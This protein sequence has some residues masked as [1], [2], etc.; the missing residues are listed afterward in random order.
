LG[1]PSAAQTT[2]DGGD[3]ADGFLQSVGWLCCVAE[4]EAGWV[5][6]M[7]VPGQRVDGDRRIRIVEPTERG[8]RL[9]AEAVERVRAV[10]AQFLSPLDA[11][12]REAFL[13]FVRRI[14][15]GSLGQPADLKGL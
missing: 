8:R 9:A 5:G 15:M 1:D 7:P 4:D 11:S 10:E 13:A 6:L 3:A 12:E 2:H 14:A